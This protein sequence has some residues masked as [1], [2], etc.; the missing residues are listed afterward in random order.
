MNFVGRKIVGLVVIMI[1]NPIQIIA[2]TKNT[3]ASIR[4]APVRKR[5]ASNPQALGQNMPTS[6]NPGVNQEFARL[7]N[8][9]HIFN[10]TIGKFPTQNNRIEMIASNNS[11]VQEKIV[12]Q[13]KAT[14]PLLHQNVHLFLDR[15]LQYKKQNGTNKEKSLYAAMNG[16]QF[17]MRLL[18]QRPLM[19]MTEADQYLLRSNGISGYGGF[20]TIGTASERSPLLLKDY[21]SYDEMSLAALIG[22]SSPTFFI[23]NGARNNRAIAG[24]EGSYEKEGIY[25]GLVGARFEKPE[26]MEWEHIIITPQQNTSANGYGLNASDKGLIA[27][28]SNLY[29]EKFP[30]FAE[31]QS[32]NSGKYVLLNNGFYFNTSVYKK[33]IRLVVEPFLVD[34]HNRALL[35]NKKAYVHTVGLGLGVWQIDNRQASYMIDVYTQIIKEN[36]L[37]YVSDIDFSW[38]GQIAENSKDEIIK[39]SAR[40][41]IAIHFSKR[42]PADKLTGKNFGKLLVACYAWD[43][44]A[45]PGNEYWAGM[46]TASGDPAAACCS[47]IPELQNPKIN[48][49]IQ[50]NSAKMMPAV[51]PVYQQLPAQQKIAP[52]KAAPA[53][54]RKV[55]VRK[56]G[57]PVRRMRK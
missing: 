6:S 50:S 4:R 47:T 55:T 31:A 56:R 42:N 26:Y 16:Q 43:G 37:S 57:V 1:I 51:A 12:V 8:Q 15:F 10:T 29:G 49:Y 38:F 21:L 5:Q 36:D 20:E 41:G 11:K 24:V 54:K 44:N 23:N 40:N 33:R 46:L 48:P 3:R 30:T 35:Q 34:A 18:E 13:A 32:D 27:L 52:K 28:W 25:V 39:A 53:A 22:I 9:S 2:V 7:F 14:Y 45:Y 17:L 19:F